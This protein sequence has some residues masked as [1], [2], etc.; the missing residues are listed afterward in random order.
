MCETQ[1]AVGW[2]WRSPKARATLGIH[3]WRSP[4]LPG[5][6]FSTLSIKLKHV[7]LYGARTSSIPFPCGRD[8]RRNSVCI[9]K[10]QP[11]GPRRDSTNMKAPKALH[12]RA[13]KATAPSLGAWDDRGGGGGLIS[14]HPLPGKLVLKR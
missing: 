12:G 3:A 13:A 10:D 9:A 8:Q 1:P 7:T 6:A 4:W 5:W 14:E 2:A 11:E